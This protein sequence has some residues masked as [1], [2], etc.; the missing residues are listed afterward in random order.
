[1]TSRQRPHESTPE[2]EARHGE[3]AP[4]SIDED[5][6]TPEQRLLARRRLGTAYLEDV[7]SLIA[8]AERADA[9][10][11]EAEELLREHREALNERDRMIEELASAIREGTGAQP[12]TQAFG[13]IRSGRD[14]RD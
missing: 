13:T 5:A 14:P 1:M 4:A 7:R 6:R 11:E 3:P 12:R 10:V 9:L 8:R 2:S